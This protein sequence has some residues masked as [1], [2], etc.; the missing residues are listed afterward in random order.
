MPS[1]L[2]VKR[3]QAF[4][5]SEERAEAEREMVKVMEEKMNECAPNESLKEAA[6]FPF[7]PDGMTR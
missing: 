6:F 2:L 1:I 7:L 3:I 5:A 4:E